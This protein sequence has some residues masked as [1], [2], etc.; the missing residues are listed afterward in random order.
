MA[1]SSSKTHASISAPVK[2]KVVSKQVKK[3]VA[4]K[5]S[6]AIEKF[7]S[8][9]IPTREIGKQMPVKGG[10]PRGKN[11]LKVQDASFEEYPFNSDDPSNTV[12][13]TL[14][15]MTELLQNILLLPPSAI[16]ELVQIVQSRDPGKVDDVG[17]QLEIDIENLKPITLHEIRAFTDFY[18]GKRAK[19]VSVP[20]VEQLGV[21]K[22]PK[23]VSQLV[24]PK[25]K[26]T[27]LSKSNATLPAPKESVQISKTR[28]FWLAGESVWRKS[29]ECLTTAS[30]LKFKSGKVSNVSARRS[31]A[32]AKPKTTRVINL[33]PGG[34]A[35]KVELNEPLAAILEDAEAPPSEEMINRLREEERERRKRESLSNPSLTEQIELMEWMEAQI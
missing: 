19:D 26:E 34:S 35:S 30:N 6:P 17:E 4:E 29:C 15:E 31:M 5:S 27:V 14:E 20:T 33:P 13:M 24:P 9:E 32:A 22:P 16:I 21:A 7:A 18:T 2:E 1:N 12:A 28:Y 10:E 11:K 3:P 23:V 8:V 25:K